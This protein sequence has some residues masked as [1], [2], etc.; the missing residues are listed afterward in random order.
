MASPRRTIHT[1]QLVATLERLAV[2][3]AAQDQL[4]A[5]AA[6]RAADAHQVV[7]NALTQQGGTDGK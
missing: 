1:S 3:G 2:A 6:Q 4:H 5:E 7:K